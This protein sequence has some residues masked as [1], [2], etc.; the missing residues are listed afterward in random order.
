ME[1][2][3]STRHHNGDHN[4][5]SIFKTEL[6]LSCSNGP[7]NHFISLATLDSARRGRVLGPTMRLQKTISLLNSQTTTATFQFFGCVFYI[8]WEQ[9][10]LNFCSFFPAAQNVSFSFGQTTPD[11]VNETTALQLGVPIVMTIT[12]SDGFLATETIVN[13]SVTGGSAT[14]GSMIIVAHNHSHV[15]LLYLLYM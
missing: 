7:G 5:G 3:I 6:A 4:R 10:H 15:Q 2:V 12:P 9:A 8:A 11:N 1:H 14:C 13:I